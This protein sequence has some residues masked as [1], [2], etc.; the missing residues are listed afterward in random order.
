MI[1][2]CWRFRQTFEGTLVE[3]ERIEQ[4]GNLLPELLT[5]PELLTDIIMAL[6]TLSDLTY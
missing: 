4:I 1:H 6:G 2:N 3:N 5:E